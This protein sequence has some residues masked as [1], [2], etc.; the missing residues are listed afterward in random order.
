MDQRVSGLER[1]GH[2]PETDLRTAPDKGTE[3][4]S[5]AFSPPGR[6][7]PWRL[8]GAILAAL[9]V[10]GGGGWWLWQQFTHVFV[11]DARVAADIV[12]LSSR[13][14]GWVT[15]V[16][17]IAGDSVR[18]G[19][20]LIRIDDRESRLLVQ[21]LD[22]Q[23]AGIARRREVIEARIKLID[24]Q[25]QSGITAETGSGRGG[26][27]RAGCRGGTTRSCQTGQ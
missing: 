12:A 4:A 26:R 25:T 13:V 22:A 6:A 11:T 18:K 24:H 15:A 9:I 16:E 23:L 3:A 10:L 21:E 27:S 2:D 19:D 1:Q 17:V 8:Y 5:E 14:P 7:R 20:I